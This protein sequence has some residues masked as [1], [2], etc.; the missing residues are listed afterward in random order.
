MGRLIENE[1]SSV[2]ALDA[3]YLVNK[4]IHQHTEV[5]GSFKRLSSL[6]H[7]IIFLLSEEEGS[8]TLRDNQSSFHVTG[9]IT[10]CEAINT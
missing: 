8:I 6:L 2:A 9:C 5:S 7:L 3:D 10:A 1:N 4:T